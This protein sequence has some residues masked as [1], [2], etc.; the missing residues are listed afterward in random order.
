MI[1]VYVF[2]GL[3]IA[4]GVLAVRRQKLADGNR[5]NPVKLSLGYHE[6]PQT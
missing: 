6:K 1:F 2:A 4:G 3:L 5:K